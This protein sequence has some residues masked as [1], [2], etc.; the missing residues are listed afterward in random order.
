MPEPSLEQQAR[1]LLRHTPGSVGAVFLTRVL[2]VFEALARDLPRES[3]SA[4][5]AAPSD[6]EVVLQAIL[7]SRE[8]VGNFDRGDNPLALAR[9]R[10]QQ[11]R[12]SLLSSEGG[13]LSAVQVAEQLQI[14][15]QA[16]NKRRQAGQL[17]ALPAGRRGFA[18][19]AWQ[20]AGGE[21]LSGLAAILEHLADHDPWMQARFFLMANKR[22][23]DVRPLDEL[24][25]GNVE[26]VIA[27]AAVYG[28]H[29]AA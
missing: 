18:Y 11:A 3:L 10:G 17:L 26:A 20:L 4:A 21:V 29:G 1:Q 16:V 22:L 23:G 8:G 9:L 24:R 28:E 15:R 13:T 5:A 19:P 2:R 25:K 27:A 6:F 12:S 14:T 7:A